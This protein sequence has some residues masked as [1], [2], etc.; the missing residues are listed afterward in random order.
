MLNNNTNK[1]QNKQSLNTLSSSNLSASV[2]EVEEE[3]VEET[4]EY[5]EDDSE[6]LERH[7][8]KKNKAD[9]A[10]PATIKADSAP[11]KDNGRSSTA[12]PPSM[13]FRASTS[14]RKVNSEEDEESEEYDVS[15]FEDDDEIF[16]T[17]E[18]TKGDQQR[19]RG[20]H[21]EEDGVDDD[22]SVQ[23]PRRSPS[24]KF[25][26]GMKVMAFEGVSTMCT[27]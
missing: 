3:D 4:D 22:V 15:K 9:V 19:A 27:G 2:L 20:K 13:S 6:V 14:Q 10:L 23:D 17:V 12:A 21:E 26:G 25:G 16:G 5:T 8:D 11:I 18:S 24:P 1:V 7:N